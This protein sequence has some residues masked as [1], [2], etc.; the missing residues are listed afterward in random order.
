MA[1]RASS[2]LERKLVLK[3]RLPLLQPAIGIINSC[4]YKTSEKL[5]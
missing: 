4:L 2:H 1:I 5:D 3:K